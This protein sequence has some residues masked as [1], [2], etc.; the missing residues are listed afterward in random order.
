MYEDQFLFKKPGPPPKKKKKKKKCVVLGMSLLTCGISKVHS[1]HGG[2]VYLFR[3]NVT[4]D[5]L[6]I[7]V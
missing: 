2:G 5:L 1:L 4:P 3:E 7:Y 6:T